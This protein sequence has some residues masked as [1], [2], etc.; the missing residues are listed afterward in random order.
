MLAT[1]DVDSSSD[2]W[3][4]ELGDR[5][6]QLLDRK[7]SSV[8]GREDSLA[9]YCRLLTSLYLKEELHGKTEPL[10]VAF[11]KSIKT[12]SSERETAYAL[13]GIP[14]ADPTSLYQVG[15]N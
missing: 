6:E 15:H 11:L 4:E 3:K 7:R 2:A 5:I 8:A 12:E 1:E 9:A 10:I 13:K 14:E